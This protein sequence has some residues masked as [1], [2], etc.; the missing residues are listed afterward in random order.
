[1]SALIVNSRIAI[2][3]RELEER[4]IKSSGPGGQN[5]NKVASAVQ[6]RFDVRA[7]LSLPEPRHQS[8][9][10]QQA[11]KAGKQEASRRDQARPRATGLGT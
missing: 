3:E 1:M 9:E 11:Q 8:A 2:A 6:L 10:S 7:S 5:V 4:F